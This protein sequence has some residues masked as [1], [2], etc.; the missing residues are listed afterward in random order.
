[1]FIETQRCGQI[2]KPL[3][4][5]DDAASHVGEG[6]SYGSG[7]TDMMSY[8]GVLRLWLACLT[9]SFV[10]N[11]TGSASRYL[12][13]FEAKALQEAADI[14]SGKTRAPAL[15]PES[16]RAAEAPKIMLGRRAKR[17]LARGLPACRRYDWFRYASPRTL[18]GNQFFELLARMSVHGRAS[19]Y[20]LEYKV[21]LCQTVHMRER[22]R[23]SR[24]S[25]AEHQQAVSLC[26]NLGL[27][28]AHLWP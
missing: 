15:I 2:Y 10:E 26:V 25:K 23:R 3:C 7:A 19:L 6:I 18:N 4:V 27:C 12:R 20:R 13:A 8:L 17:I 9:E 14:A 28:A 24:A 11:F 22:H 21:R 5:G 1:M 16:A